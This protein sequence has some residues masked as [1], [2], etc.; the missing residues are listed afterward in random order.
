[1]RVTATEGKEAIEDF[2]DS[3]YVGL[4]KFTY[5]LLSICPGKI[6]EG[7]EGTPL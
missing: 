6:V 3:V 2:W 4:R 1:M 7:R 5:P